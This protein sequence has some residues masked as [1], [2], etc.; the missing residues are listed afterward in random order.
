[1]NIAY[2]PTMNIAYTPTMNIAY[3]TTMNIAYTPKRSVK[4]PLSAVERYLFNIKYTV[5]RLNKVFFVRIMRILA[6][7]VLN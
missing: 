3:T 7:G 6:K 1:M 4:R 5:W 2:T